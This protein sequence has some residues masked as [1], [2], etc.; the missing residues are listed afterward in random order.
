MRAERAAK[1]PG[2]VPVSEVFVAFRVWR[3]LIEPRATGRVPV[4]LFSFKFSDVNNN[5]FPS[6]EGMVPVKLPLTLSSTIFVRHPRDE[7]RVPSM[8]QAV[9]EK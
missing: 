1:L 9:S 5:K 2:I 8:Q 3:L 7:G 6:E 4:R